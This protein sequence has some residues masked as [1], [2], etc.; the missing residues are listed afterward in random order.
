METTSMQMSRLQAYI[1]PS[2]NSYLELMNRKYRNYDPGKYIYIQLCQLG[3]EA[4]LSD[5]YIELMYITLHAWN[6]NSRGAC[7]V[8]YKQFKDSI[9]KH[10]DRIRKLSYQRIESVSLASVKDDI[11]YLF[12]N[13][14]VVSKTQ[15]S[16][17]VAMSK[18][19]HFL[20][21]NL[22]IPMD[23]KFTL[24]I[25]GGTADGTIE[26]QFR[27]Y[28]RITQDIQQFVSESFLEK[29]IDLSGWN[30][31]I[32]KIV[33]NIIIGKGMEKKG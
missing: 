6:M 1:G 26:A 14:S 18:T 3:N 33:D 5:K 7:L 20:C 27:K 23:R 2:V 24:Q 30:Q 12:N 22:L 29:E 19:L 16:R 17:F 4:F 10:E 28:W 15:K 11:K 9:R 32:P 13:L 8:G 21:P 25:Y 31:N